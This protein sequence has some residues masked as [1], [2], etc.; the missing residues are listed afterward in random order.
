MADDTAEDARQAVAHPI[1]PDE[2]RRIRL[3]PGERLIVRVG[4][5]S[6]LT[7]YQIREYQEHLQFAVP[8][9]PVLVLFADEVVAESVR[10]VGGPVLR[11]QQYIVGENDGCAIPPGMLLGARVTH[12]EPGHQGATMRELIDGARVSAQGDGDLAD[13]YGRSVDG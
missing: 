1:V 2:V 9:N 11:G 12:V 6:G 3:E 13:R 5:D 8:D 4:T 10:A 7:P